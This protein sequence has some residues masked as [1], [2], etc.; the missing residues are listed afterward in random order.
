MYVMTAVYII[1]DTAALQETR[2]IYIAE[3]GAMWTHPHCY[4]DIIL[5]CTGGV[6]EQ[7][8]C[9]RDGRIKFTEGSIDCDCVDAGL[10]QTSHLH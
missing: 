7:A 2:M 1:K 6:V 4:F 5:T 3:E 10:F 8:G 9:G